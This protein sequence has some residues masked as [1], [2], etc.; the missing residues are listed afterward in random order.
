MASEGPLVSLSLSARE[1]ARLDLA[2]QLLRL[3]LFLFRFP[4][5]FNHAL[6][7]HIIEIT[8]PKQSVPNSW[9]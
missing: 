6:Y 2:E 9:S 5:I 8:R 3:V 7:T 4:A 1:P